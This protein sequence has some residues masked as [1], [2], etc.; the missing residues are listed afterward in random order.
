[1]LVVLAGLVL[2]GLMPRLIPV[3]LVG[4]VGLVLVLVL[5]VLVVLVVLVVLAGLMGRCPSSTLFS[6]INRTQTIHVP[7]E[8]AKNS[9]TAVGTIESPMYFLW[10]LVEAGPGALPSGYPGHYIKPGKK[11]DNFFNG[12]CVYKEIQTFRI[13]LQ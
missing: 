9:K 8:A 7:V 5:A 12:F 11:R 4:L 3:G 10:M 2:A 6:H 13:S 1:V